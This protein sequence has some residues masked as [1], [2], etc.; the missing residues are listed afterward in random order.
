MELD[1]GAFSVI[2]K[3]RVTVLCTEFFEDVLYVVV[4]RFI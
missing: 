2:G 1:R 4:G 3:L